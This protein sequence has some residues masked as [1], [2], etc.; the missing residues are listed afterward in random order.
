MYNMTVTSQLLFTQLWY[1]RFLPRGLGRNRVIFG[2]NIK[3]CINQIMKRKQALKS[4]CLNIYI[5]CAI[6]CIS[7][8]EFLLLPQ[9]DQA[10]FTL[11]RP[12]SGKLERGLATPLDSTNKNATPLTEKGSPLQNLEV[13]LEKGTRP[14]SR[15]VQ[16]CA[17]QFG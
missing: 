3:P 14:N 13:T 8:C 9:M 2:R 16:S 17:Y 11:D 6:P 7:A 15:Y 5:Y 10:A 4:Y 1:I 12:K